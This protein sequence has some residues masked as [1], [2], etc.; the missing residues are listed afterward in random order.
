MYSKSGNF[1]Y[2]NICVSNVCI[3]KFISVI[4]AYTGHTGH[5]V[6]NFRVLFIFMVWTNSY[7]NYLTTRISQFTIIMYCADLGSGTGVLLCLNALF[8]FVV[9]SCSK[10]FVCLY[11]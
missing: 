4:R 5:C 8:M 10:V 6:N 2:K 11:N 1:R 3:Y 9:L 7:E